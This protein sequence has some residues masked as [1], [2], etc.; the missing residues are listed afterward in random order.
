MFGLTTRG[1]LEE[2]EAAARSARRIHEDMVK[3][4]QAELDRAKERIWEL[5]ADVRAADAGAEFQ[6]DR[7]ASAEAEVRRLTE[8]LVA[9]PVE[10]LPP[11]E[12]PSAAPD[13]SGSVPRVLSGLEVVARATTHRNIHQLT[14]KGR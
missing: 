14:G 4:L 10:A 8:I 7:A 3:R 11:A 6:R 5:M 2:A 1:R 13:A 9:H 12:K